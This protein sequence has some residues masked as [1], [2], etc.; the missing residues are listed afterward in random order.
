MDNLR[1]IASAMPG[2]LAGL[3]STRRGLL[4]TPMCP[5]R[6]PSGGNRQTK[7]DL[8]FKNIASLQK[9]VARIPTGVEKLQT[10]LAHLRDS[11]ARHMELAVTQPATVLAGSTA[12]RANTSTIAGLLV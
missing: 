7:L 10:E 3:A 1:Q 8:L 11:L 9:G 6:V 12:E 2:K 4:S 5:Q